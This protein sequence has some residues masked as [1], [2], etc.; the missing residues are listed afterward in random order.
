MR[1]NEDAEP[2]ATGLQQMNRHRIRSEFNLF[3]MIPV[4][5]LYMGVREI[6][7]RDVCYQRVPRAG[8][9]TDRV[10]IIPL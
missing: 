1:S 9:V 5:D 7:R 8:L 10:I 2:S 4:P 6:V 3:E